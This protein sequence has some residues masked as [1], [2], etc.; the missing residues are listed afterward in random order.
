MR[1]YQVVRS[2]LKKTRILQK[3]K[4][5][6]GFIPVTK[7]YKYDNLYKMLTQFPTVFVKPD[8]GSKGFRVAAIMKHFEGY[9]VHFNSTVIKMQTLDQVNEFVKELSGSKKFL[10]QQGINVLKVD[11]RPFNV[12]VWAQK[13]YDTW[14]VSGITAVLAAPQ[15]L[16]TNYQQGGTLIS[17]EKVMS[18]TAGNDINKVKELTSQLYSIGQHASQVLNQHYKGLREL[19]IDIAIDQSFWPWILEVNTKPMIIIGNPKIRHYHSIIKKRLRKKRLRTP[20][21]N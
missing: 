15:K 1:R 21:N 7:T 14:K 4:D 12:R 19:G 10:I 17:Y 5:I 2:K 6:S 20:V 18:K 3:D 11:N 13:P 16:I 8:R 9:S